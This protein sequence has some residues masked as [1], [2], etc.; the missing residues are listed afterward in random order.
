[1]DDSIQAFVDQLRSLLQAPDPA[2]TAELVVA[3]ATF[4]GYCEETNRRLRECLA[5]IS[6]GQYAN[7]VELTSKGLQVRTS[8]FG[9]FCEQ[10][11]VLTRD[12][13]IT[14]REL[15]PTDESLESVFGYLISS[16][17]N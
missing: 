10:I 7:A 9:A 5:L 17:G 11:A 1:M 4:G 6:K 12:H 2:Q 14:L 16:Q 15:L 13:D 8:D 3:L